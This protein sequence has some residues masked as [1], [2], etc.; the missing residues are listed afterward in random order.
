[1]GTLDSQLTFDILE[2]RCRGIN[3]HTRLPPT[4]V[5]SSTSTRRIALPRLRTNRES[6]ETPPAEATVC[7]LDTEDGT[8]LYSAQ[9]PA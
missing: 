8:P 1:M 3:V 7:I 6:L 9:V 4:E 2:V 5:L